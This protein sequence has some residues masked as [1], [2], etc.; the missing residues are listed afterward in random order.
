M[1]ALGEAKYFHCE[2]IYSCQ[3]SDRVLARDRWFPWGRWP[4]QQRTRGG[5]GRGGI[6]VRRG[7]WDWLFPV[8]RN[9]VSVNTSRGIDRQSEVRT[10][11]TSDSHC[12]TGDSTTQTSVFSTLAVVQQFDRCFLFTPRKLCWITWSTKL[13]HFPHKPLVAHDS[14]N[15][16]NTIDGSEF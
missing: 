7:L 12:D 6:R 9:M 16:V 4:R 2:G 15:Y 1:S 13:I 14:Y 3:Q 11:Q 5:C 10:W 8:I